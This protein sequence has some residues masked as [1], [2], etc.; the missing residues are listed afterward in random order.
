MLLTANHILTD[1]VQRLAIEAEAAEKHTLHCQHVD[2]CYL[3]LDDCPKCATTP[4][5]RERRANVRLGVWLGLAGLATLLGV[6]S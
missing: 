4:L 1:R 2:D 6:L 3:V 5:E